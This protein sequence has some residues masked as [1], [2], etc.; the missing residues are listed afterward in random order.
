MVKVVSIRLF[1]YRYTGYLGFLFTDFKISYNISM[2]LYFNKKKLILVVTNLHNMAEEKIYNLPNALSFYR[3]LVFPLILYFLIVGKSELFSVF[4]CI[5]LVTD[6]LDGIIARTFNM[7]TKFGARLDSLG[8]YGTYF[9]AFGG[10]F[11]FKK[12]DLAEHG[13]ILYIFMFLFVFS[14]LIH[15]VRFHTFS[16]MHLYSFKITGYLQGILFFLWFFIGFYPVWYYFAI[17]FG[18]LAEMETLIIM[19]ILKEKRLDAKGLY[20]ILKNRNE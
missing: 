13:W 1:L 5:N 15:F 6:F 9:L 14:Q 19:L 20:W 10:I 12:T 11:I 2:L 18:L 16:S 7:V 17:S 3:I 8:D 4:L